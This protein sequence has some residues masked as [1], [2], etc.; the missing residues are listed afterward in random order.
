MKLAKTLMTMTAVACLWGCGQ[1]LEEPAK[2]QVTPDRPIA[3][4]N[5]TGEMGTTRQQLVSG[6]SIRVASGTYSITSAIMARWNAPTGHSNADYVT[7]AKV[8]S[9]VTDYISWQYVNTTS[10]SGTA[11]DIYIPV[12]TP[13][14]GSSYEVRY[15][16]ADGT[17]AAVSSGFPIQ[18]TPN[19]NCGTT[20]SGGQLPVAYTVNMGLQTGAFTF[21]YSGGGS[22]PDQFLVYQGDGTPLFDS[23]PVPG[24]ST[25]G[26]ISYTSGAYYYRVLVRVKPDTSNVSGTGWSWRVN[27]P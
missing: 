4:E 9:A 8:G 12:G 17:L 27:C 7:V 2:T 26:A 21:Y 24:A 5:S 14:D 23:G 10:T 20:I 25:T 13:L 6:Y 1:G 11:S 16:L 15:F 3:D 18:A 19:I 22:I